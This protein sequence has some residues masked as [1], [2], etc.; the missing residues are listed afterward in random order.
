VQN[1]FSP[2]AELFGVDI[3]PL[4]TI[5][6]EG[7]VYTEI[8]GCD[9]W[10]VQSSESNQFYVSN[11]LGVRRSQIREDPTDAVLDLLKLDPTLLGRQVKSPRLFKNAL[12]KHF[13][14]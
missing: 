9:M 1:P 11:E 8:R 13:L 5:H 12:V 6:H 2:P 14:S 4:D 7:M 3:N 10:L